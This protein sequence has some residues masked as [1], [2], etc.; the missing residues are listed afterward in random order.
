MRASRAVVCAALLALA[1][2]G[3]GSG[4]D[5][6]ELW[7]FG[8]EGEAVEEL[9]AGFRERNPQIAVR[10]QRIPW[11]AAH[12]KLLT[13]YVGGSMPDVFQLGNTWVAEFA[14]LGALESLDEAAARSSSLAIADFF[15]GTTDANR[16][17]ERLMALPWY[18]DTRLLFYRRDL[19]A[20][21]G[22]A[23]PPRSWSQW[24]E[25]MRAVA[26]RSGG[27]TYGVFAAAEEWQTPVVLALQRGASLLAQGDAYGNFRS[28]P[29]RE[30]FD[31]YHGLFRDGLAPR[32]ASAE[33]VG[34]YREFAAGSFAFFVTGPWNVGELGRR[35][36]PELAGAWTTAPMPSPDGSGIGLSLAGGA[37]LAI[38]S[39]SP[40]KADAWAL[41]EYLVEPE[42]QVAL[43]RRSGDLPSRRSAWSDRALAADERL[44]AFRVQLDRLAATP[45]IPEWERIAAK[46]SLHAERLVRGDAALDDAL[47]DLDRDVDAILEKRRWLKERGGQQAAQAARPSVAAPGSEQ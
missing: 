2:C 11:S 4:G 12:E 23:E 9:L 7:A 22:I 34:V 36:P 3:R 29:V 33:M 13:A 44:G 21:A 25:A 24:R 18:V 35:M 39:A 42:V 46:I 26:E 41:V 38:S 6:L 43:A 17:G 8:S 19:L 15:E 28:A 10:V 20:R 16:I 37:S 1:A 5:E 31:F 32:R 30:A 14:A 27:K 45:K 47:A 40:R